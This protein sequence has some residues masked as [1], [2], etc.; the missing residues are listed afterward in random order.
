MT[1]NNPTE[2]TDFQRDRIGAALRGTLEAKGFM[3]V[4]KTADADRLLSWH[5]SLMEKP[6]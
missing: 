4:D 6:I 1:G 2:L 3:L 5:L